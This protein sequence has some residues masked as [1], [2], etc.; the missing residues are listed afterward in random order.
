MRA[1][2]DFFDAENPNP[3]YKILIHSRDVPNEISEHGIRNPEQSKTM[4][5]RNTEFV[6]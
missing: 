3:N 1:D 4:E 5:L 2:L 6:Y